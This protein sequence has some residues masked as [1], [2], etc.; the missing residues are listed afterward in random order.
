MSR[1]KELTKRKSR[2]LAS[3]AATRRDAAGAERH[4]RRALSQDPK[5][6]AARLGL[7]TL[8]AG[9]AREDEAERV[10]REG[11]AG[12]AQPGELH[13]AL[14]LLAGQR[15]QWEKAAHELRAAA[16]LMP[17]HPR[18]RR[19]LDAVERYLQQTR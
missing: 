8:L 16:A 13:F 12:A 18:V 14:G 9:S 6:Q 1:L 11:L 5:V 10:L 15:K 2:R 19:N 3:L 4:Y 17:D 7:A